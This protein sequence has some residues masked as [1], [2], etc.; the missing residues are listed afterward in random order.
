ME[1][2]QTRPEGEASP[3]ASTEADDG[4]LSQKISNEISHLYKEHLGKGP[5][6]SRTY[7][8]PELIVVVLGGGY[9]A[10]E[11]TMFEAGRWYEVRRARQHW[12]DSMKVRFIDKIE[13]LTGRKVKGFMSAN[14]QDPDLAVELFVLHPE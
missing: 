14:T 3:G 4:A 6:T 1:G 5:L 11:Q 8:H 9:S 10:G 13:G 12:Q 7:V 2:R